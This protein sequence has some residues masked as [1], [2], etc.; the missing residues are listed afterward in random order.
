MNKQFEHY[1]IMIGIRS[2]EFTYSDK[3]LFENIDYFRDCYNRNLSAYKA[4]IF[5]HDILKPGEK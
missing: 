5:L 2:D 1:L 4:L 3:E